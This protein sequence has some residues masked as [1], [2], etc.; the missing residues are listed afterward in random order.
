M[1]LQVQVSL[2]GRPVGKWP[3]DREKVGIGRSPDNAI[4]LDTHVVSRHHAVFERAGAGFALRDLGTVNGT[5]L[6]GARLEGTQPVQA[7]DSIQIG[8]FTLA[9]QEEGG[10]GP[11][12]ALRKDPKSGEGWIAVASTRDTARDRDARERAAT[13]RA[14]LVLNGSPGPPRAL[15]KDVYQI[16]K[17]AACD[18]RL[19]GVFA[20]RKLALIVRGHGGWKLVNVTPDGKRVERNG[21]AVAD[22]TWLEDGDR[23]LLYDMEAAFHEGA[24]G[25]DFATL[26]MRPP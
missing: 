7:G 17:D 4:Q 14:Y 8:I 12:P 25:E 20:P 3:L 5:Y 23:L 19:E 13:M 18:L 22:Q 6:N 2:N 26:A 11:M 10:S 1:A 24:P 21:A 9:V 15:E 16:G